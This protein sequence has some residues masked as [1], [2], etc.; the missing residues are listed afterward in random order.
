MA[1]VRAEHNTQHPK[2]KA[3]E[4]VM[5]RCKLSCKLQ[6]IV[7]KKAVLWYNAGKKTYREAHHEAAFFS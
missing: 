3:K 7:E 1:H 2:N 5:N 6:K 4:N